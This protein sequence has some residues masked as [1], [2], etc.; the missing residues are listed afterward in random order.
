MRHFMDC[1]GHTR[2][3][4][5][6]IILAPRGQALQQRVARRRQ[7]KNTDRLWYQLLDL[8]RTLPVDFE[9]HIPTLRQA[10]VYPIPRSSIIVAEYFGMFE[11]VAIVPHAPEFI[12]KI[13]RASCRERV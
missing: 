11:E 10:F 6:G 4:D 8:R 13:G 7:Y 1:L 12:F 9:D 5:F 2:G 3:N